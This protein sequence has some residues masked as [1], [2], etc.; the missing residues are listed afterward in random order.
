MDKETFVKILAGAG[1]LYDKEIDKEIMEMWLSF[2]KDNTTE[3]FKKAMNEHIKTS[4]YFP[5]VADIKE[6]IYELN[7]SNESDTEL[8]EKL[9]SAIRNSSYHSEEEF[10]KL[11]PVVQEYVRS[12]R[13]L[14][15]LAVMDSEK[16]HTIVKGQFL[17]QIANIKENFKKYEITGNK[18]LLQEKGIYQIE[19]VID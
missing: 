17:K 16:I 2:F 8:W 12:P 3:E 9:L 13:Q 7:N 10:E 19:E 11:P 6:K 14:Q 15:E 5:T 1:K 18:K 4:R